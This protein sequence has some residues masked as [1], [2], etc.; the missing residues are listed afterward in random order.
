MK[1][2]YYTQ[3]KWLWLWILRIVQLVASIVALGLAAADAV[4]YK[5][6]N[7][8]IPW[9]LALNLA[10]AALSFLACIYL[11]LSTGKTA[12]LPH[13]P[14]GQVSI[15]L[16]LVALWIAV[17]ATA[18]LSSMDVCKACF[19]SLTCAAAK[20]S[21]FLGDVSDVPADASHFTTDASDLSADTS[22][23]S[24]DTGDLS[25]DTSDTS[26]G[27][28]DGSNIP[29]GFD[30][31]DRT[32]WTH[33]FNAGDFDANGHAK[34]DAERFGLKD[35]NPAA[36]DNDVNTKRHL[37]KLFKRDVGKLLFRRKK[38]SSSRSKG[39]KGGTGA[40]LETARQ[41]IAAI[42][43]I[44]YFASLVATLFTIF[45]IYFRRGRRG[46]AT[47]EPVVEQKDYAESSAPSEQHH[48]VH[49]GEPYQHYSQQ[50]YDPP[51]VSSAPYTAPYDP[52][53]HYETSHVPSSPQ[54][55]HQ[56]PG[57]YHRV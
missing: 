44:L 7:C 11:I 16:I 33:D 8:S 25:A 17:A 35:A 42:L 10:V 20:T 32:T 14:F 22:D 52:P 30:P 9:K 28:G 34:G 6:V 39:G 18:K 53:Q 38:P 57:T 19:S 23:L 26:V 3:T 1:S 29:P 55:Y 27:P 5:D 36:F 46:A 40:S 2:N 47:H 54:P 31:N 12:I 56:G 41:A 37:G 45:K 49:A 24:T 15:D 21:D 48:S 13:H 4:K 43:V 50:L 51:T